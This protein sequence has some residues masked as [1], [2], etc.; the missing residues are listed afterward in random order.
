MVLALLG[1][2]VLSMARYCSNKRI[3]NI[4]RR[5]GKK[6]LSYVASTRTLASELRHLTLTR[7]CHIGKRFDAVLS[8][9]T[10]LTKAVFA[11]IHE[12]EGPE[13]GSKKVPLT[14]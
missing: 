4:D 2:A 13:W 1:E 9:W 5:S 11:D 14:G 10:P 8:N 3:R 6:R 7:F 12:H